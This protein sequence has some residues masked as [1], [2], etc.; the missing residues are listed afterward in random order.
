MARSGKRK[1]AG[2]NGGRGEV[3]TDYRYPSAKRKNNPPAT[4]AAEGVVPAIPKAQYSYSP[5]LPPELRFD[6]DGRPEALPDLLAESTRRKLTADEAK[7]LAAALRTQE[8]WL[9]WVG[10]REANQRGFEVDPVALH[11]HERV[12][13]QAILKVAARQD[14]N[15]S[16]FADPEQEYR[17]DELLKDE[18]FA[19][20]LELR[21]PLLHRAGASILDLA[22][23]ADIGGARDF[24]ETVDHHGEILSSAGVGLLFH[25]NDKL[26]ATLYYGYPFKDTYRTSDLQDIGIHFDLV[27]QLF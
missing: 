15:Y 20:T 22:P 8:P 6:P 3:A 18:A 16:L 26:S 9:E 24:H 21:L 4:I 5:R 23:F 13:A 10:K 2:G 17:E 14:I 12:S 7:T 1:A 11:I 19:A 27:I 25:P